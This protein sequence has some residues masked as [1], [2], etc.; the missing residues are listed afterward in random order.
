MAEGTLTVRISDVTQALSSG[1][2]KKKPR[3]IVDPAPRDRLI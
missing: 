1:M 2:T 3:F